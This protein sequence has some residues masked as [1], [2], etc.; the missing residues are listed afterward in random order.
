MK[1]SLNNHGVFPFI[2][3]IAK[4]EFGLTPQVICSYGTQVCAVGMLCALLLQMVE[5]YLKNKT[6]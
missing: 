4:T 6:K 2:C 5:P 1:R 3:N